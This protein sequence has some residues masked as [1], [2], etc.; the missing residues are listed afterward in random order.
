MAIDDCDADCFAL[1]TLLLAARVIVAT[2]RRTDGW[3][4]GHLGLLCCSSSVGKQ[5]ASKPR[6][7]GVAKTCQGL[8]CAR[9]KRHAPS[10]WMD[11]TAGNGSRDRFQPARR[12]G[13]CHHYQATDNH[14]RSANYYCCI[15]PS[16]PPSL[17]HPPPRDHLLRTPLGI[18]C[19]R[20]A[21]R[22]PHCPCLTPLLDKHLEHNVRRRDED[23]K[24]DHQQRRV[25]EPE[26]LGMESKRRQDWRVSK[27]STT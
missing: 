7:G 17:S 6:G 25:R 22:T 11:T 1:C 8:L 20:T 2:R 10:R 12:H 3:T 26:R 9:V 23:A 5:A 15:R 13:G 24:D 19:R 21:A 16:Q 18:V 4:G 27:G 14:F